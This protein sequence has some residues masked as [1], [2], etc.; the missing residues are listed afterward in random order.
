MEVPHIGAA[1]S[2]QRRKSHKLIH[3][4]CYKLLVQYHILRGEKRTCCNK[5]TTACVETLKS[6]ICHVQMRYLGADIARIKNP[7]SKK[8]TPTVQHDMYISNYNETTWIPL[9]FN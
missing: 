5:N 3:F 7:K 2:Y 8:A 9:Q 4:A 6:F 1:K